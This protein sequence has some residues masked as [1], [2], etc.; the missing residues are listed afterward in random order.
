V[1]IEGI[2]FAIP[3][4]DVYGMLEDLRDFGY[5]KGAYLGVMVLDVDQVA[6]SYG[7]PAGAYIKQ[8]TKGFG[9]EEAG[10]KAQ[11]II[12]DLGGYEVGSVADLTRAL[13]KFEVGETTT[14]TVYRSGQELTMDITLN[15]KP[16]AQQQE[17]TETPAPEYPEYPEYYNP[18]D[19]F[20]DWYQEFMDRFFNGM[21]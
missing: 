14:V 17:P 4:D 5:V 12:I 1:G 16:Q 15:E 13:R 3:M 6:Q 11:D 2:G 19:M 9:A 21:G 10:L 18:E 7:L 8:V 20:E